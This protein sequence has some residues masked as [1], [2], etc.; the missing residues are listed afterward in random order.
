MYDS[1]GTL[2]TVTTYN[3]GVD[4][5]TL[6]VEMRTPEGDLHGKEIHRM[7]LEGRPIEITS[8]HPNGEILSRTRLSYDGHGKMAER[9]SSGRGG[10]LRE[11]FSY[12]YDEH[13]N[14][15]RKTTQRVSQAWE[16][17]SVTRRSIDYYLDVPT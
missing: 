3:H 4:N 2:A 6:T 16:Q 1:G 5:Q 14:W 13:G 7:D 8:F 11:F 10:D 15:T 9:I 12:Q 17:R